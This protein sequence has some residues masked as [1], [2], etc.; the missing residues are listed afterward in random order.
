MKKTY[1]LIFAMFIL[2]LLISEL[3]LNYKTKELQDQILALQN[4][5]LTIKNDETNK[6]TIIQEPISNDELSQYIEQRSQSFGIDPKIVKTIIAIES[7]NNPYALG[8]ISNKPKTI[9]LALSG[10]ENIEIKNNENSTLVSLLPK[11]AKT[12]SDLFEILQIYKAQWDIKTIDYGLMQ[13]NHET[14]LSYDLQPKE[15]YLNTHY[16]IAIGIDVLKTCFNRFKD[17][18]FNTIECYNKG[19]NKDKLDQS[20]DYYEKFIKEYKRKYAS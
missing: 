3:R 2:A 15:I 17:N 16:N 19:M 13:I 4:P 8:V 20:N 14:I 9:I 10:N 6:T 7:K 12:A 11:D 5:S 18:Q 1:I